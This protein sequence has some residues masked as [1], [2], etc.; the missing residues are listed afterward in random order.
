MAAQIISVR[1]DTLGDRWR[2]VAFADGDVIL[3]S[4][5]YPDCADAVRAAC[6][7]AS[8]CGADVGAIYV[9]LEASEPVTA[10]L[11]SCLDG[12]GI[13]VVAY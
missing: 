12:C 6:L 7:L 3:H 2:Y 4:E 13:R 10:Y 5:E 9:P 1:I 11:D 8:G